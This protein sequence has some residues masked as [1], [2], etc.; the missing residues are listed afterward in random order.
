MRS[1]THSERRRSSLPLAALL[2]VASAALALALAGGHAAQGH[3][4][5]H[6]H[7]A[8]RTA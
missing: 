2:A 1:N 8:K 3:S 7:A 6:S 5:E 4:E